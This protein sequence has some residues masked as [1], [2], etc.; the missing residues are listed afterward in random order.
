MTPQEGAIAA[1]ED[2]YDGVKVPIY[3]GTAADDNLCGEWKVGKYFL[4]HLLTD[5]DFSC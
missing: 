1:I 2:V 4:L 5:S 3:G